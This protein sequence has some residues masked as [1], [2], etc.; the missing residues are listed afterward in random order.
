MTI[1]ANF[2]F[3]ARADYEAIGLFWAKFA[4]LTNITSGPLW[5][6]TASRLAAVMEQV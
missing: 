5:A 3:A 4:I 2:R 1:L 6:T